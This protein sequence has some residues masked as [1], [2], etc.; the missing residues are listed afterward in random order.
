MTG[1]VTAIRTQKRRRDRANVYLDE[2]YAF[3]LQVILA[4]ELRIGQA[5]S[6]AEIRALQ[7]RDMGESVYDA[8]LRYLSFRPRS[9]Q[10]IRRYLARRDLSEQATDEVLARL[11]RLGFSND[12]QFAAFWVENREAFRP[13]GR[14][15]LRAELRQKGV[16]DEVIEDALSEVDE[17]QSAQRAAEQALRRY[18]R[19]DEQTF[20]RRLLA[21]LQR[22][23]FGYGVARRVTDR[24]WHELEAQRSQGD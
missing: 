17:E 9:E 14:W 15:A 7:A 6:D 24:L 12:R 2:A 20:R 22:R 16:A 10:E 3:S 13:R 8:A 11:S 19:N 1:T 18:A 4:A 23:G 21:Y 5:L